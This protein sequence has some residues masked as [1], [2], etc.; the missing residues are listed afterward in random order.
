MH[1][2]FLSISC[3]S[4]LHTHARA[5]K[6]TCASTNARHRHTHLTLSITS[7]HPS[8]ATNLFRYLPACLSPIYSRL[9]ISQR[10]HFLAL[11]IA[12]YRPPSPLAHHLC[13]SLPLSAPRAKHSFFSVG[14]MKEKAA[15]VERKG[16][17]DG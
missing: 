15:V 4:F 9:F 10:T 1:Q 17:V 6:H 14:I 5:R 12:P 8:P 11:S 2:L 16:R 7:S 13:C 3:T